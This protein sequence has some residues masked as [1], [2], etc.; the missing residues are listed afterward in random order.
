[1]TVREE[2]YRSIKARLERIGIKEDG[3]L[4]IYGE[5]SLPRLFTPAIRHLDLWNRN[6]EFIEQEA[7]WERPAVF[8]EF[9][10]IRWDALVTGVEYRADVAVNLHVVTDWDGGD[11]IG[12][13]RLLE[14]IHEVLAG[15]EG[16][17]F[18]EFDIRIST[19][20]HDHEEIVENIESYGCVGFRRL[21]PRK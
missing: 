17:T 1:M 13:F 15:L 12:E 7:A 16:E 20:N 10:P 21:Q 11:G 19:T 9:A 2:L 18:C 14:I 3:K 8:V 6:V 5:D 4:F